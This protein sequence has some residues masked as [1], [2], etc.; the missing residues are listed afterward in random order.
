M[1]NIKFRLTVM[2]FLEFAVWGAYLT[3]MG[4]YLATHGM[5][6]NIG[7]FYSIQ[8]IVSLFMPALMGIVADRWIPAQKALSL[9]HA[10]AGLFMIATGSYA[11]MAGDGVVFSTLFALY[12]AS[13][14]F[15]M[16]TLAL[17]NSVAYTALTQANLDTVKAFPPIRVL[18]TVGFIVTMWVVDLCGFQAT[19]NQFLVSGGLS[20]VLALYSLTLPSCPVKGHV[21]NKSLV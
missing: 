4:T 1:K 20:L 14:A 17:S 8:G 21:E 7:W 3:S 2:N 10:L 18:G 5:A 15:F 19:P 16:P 12:T 13:V 6:T 11:L 9:C